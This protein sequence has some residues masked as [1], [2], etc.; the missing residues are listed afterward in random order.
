MNRARK[1]F[2]IA[3]AAAIIA[4]AAAHPAGAQHNPETDFAFTRTSDLGGVIITGFAGT[5]T[6]VSIPPEIRGLPVVEIAPGAFAQTNQWGE[7]LQGNLTSV[8]IPDSV[9][10]IGENAFAH[11]RLTSAAIGSGVT[12]IGQRAFAGNQLDSVVIPDSV[13]SIGGGAFEN[14]RLTSLSIGSGVAQISW[15]AFADNQLAGVTIPDSVTSIGHS[16][17]ENNRLTDVTLGNSV[18]SIEERAFANNQLASLTLP[19]SVRWIRWGAFGGNQLASI[20]IGA[21]LS[22]NEWDES[23][24]QGF[25]AT[26]SQSSRRAD[27]CVLRGNA[28]QE[29]W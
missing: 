20:T 21:G 19:N 13:T 16:A 5:R 1:A 18:A 8:V 26:Y 6:D 14:N 7:A 9:R 4:I 23:L 11:N 24:P 10:T 28:W 2:G 22:F 17:F 15:R 29:E 25:I 3:A 27:T 12:N